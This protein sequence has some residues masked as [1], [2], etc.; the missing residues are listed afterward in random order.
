MKEKFDEFLNKVHGISIVQVLR[1]LGYDVPEKDGKYIRVSGH[2]GLIVDT[3][4]NRY[5]WN[6]RGEGGDTIRFVEKR[7][8]TDF[9]GALEWFERNFAL[10]M[11]AKSEKSLQERIAFRA[12]MDILELAAAYYRRLMRGGATAGGAGGGD[13]DSP[14]A[15]YCHSRGWTN[16]TIEREGLGWTGN[17]NNAGLKQEFALYQIDVTHPM[18]VALIGY[19]GDIV[20]WC[21]KHG[22][23]PEPAWVEKKRIGGLANNA[24]VYFHRQGARIGYVS[25]RAIDPATEKQFQ[26]L[27]IKNALTGQ[28]KLHY[29]NHCYTPN[30]KIVAVVEGQADAIALGQLGVA[31][32]ALC[33][34]NAKHET[35]GQLIL[36]LE[37]HSTVGVMVDN[38]DAG[39]KNAIGLATRFGMMTRVAKVG[40]G[41]DAAEWLELGATTDDVERAIRNAI[42]VVVAKA[43]NAINLD[44]DELNK[45]ML[46]IAMA[47]HSMGKV[48]RAVIEPELWRVLSPVFSNINKQNLVKMLTELAKQEQQRLEKKREGD[49]SAKPTVETLGGKSPETDVLWE[50]G[51]LLEPVYKVGEKRLVF[52][53]RDADGNVKEQAFFESDE[54]I[55]TPPGKMGQII[56]NGTVLFASEIGQERSIGELMFNVRSFIHD[57]VDIDDTY[58][59]LAVFFVLFTWMFDS[60]TMTPYLRFLGDW[61]TGKSRAIQTVGAL[62]YRAMLASGAANAA[63]VFRLISKYRGTLLMDEADIQ[64]SET[65]NLM[66]KVYNQGNQVGAPVLRSSDSARGFEVE[67]FDV[68]CPKV[69]GTRK[70]FRDRATESRCLTKTMSAT[71]REIPAVLNRDFYAR[72]QEIRNDLLMYRMR[73]WVPYRDVENV[74]LKYEISGRFRQMMLPLRELI[75]TT[76]TAENLEQLDNFVANLQRDLQSDMLT[77][78][79]AKAL[80]AIL[81]M[82]DAAIAGLADGKELNVVLDLRTIAERTN[83]II[84]EEN[85]ENG[86]DDDAVADGN[87]KLQLQGANKGGFKKLTA[88]SVSGLI[89]NELNLP[90][91]RAND[92]NRA[93][94]IPWNPETAKR[95]ETL[96]KRYGYENGMHKYKIVGGIFIGSDEGE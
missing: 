61:G 4:A 33:G 30:A 2:G 76:G 59:T 45:L 60:F 83:Q 72:A 9:M 23:A 66:I 88:R 49:K 39:S 89:R 79:Q 17:D 26:K 3:L 40:E 42:P 85:A 92:K 16:E 20:G 8:N 27:N 5:Y 67:A 43:E 87:G 74:K 84:N 70:L 71:T 24:L 18:A 52:A 29:T 57:Y 64:D 54:F 34:L 12:K 6:E 55:F 93:S 37:S 44:G 35:F 11:P 91:D 50:K 1:K 28:D 7:I 75:S 73:Y 19:S 48:T 65:E 31:A 14:A 51:I 25:T 96:R 38:D 82:V 47:H 53:V 56:R 36:Q 63:P 22:I 80:Q 32:V 68:F 10:Q 94:I 41:K 58:E 86:D 81:E 21:R 13:F 95:I 77:S 90:V 78:K 62:C 46:E 69:I 15:R